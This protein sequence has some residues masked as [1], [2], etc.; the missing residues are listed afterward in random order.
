MKT[1][2]TS[3][4]S[5][6]PGYWLA[7]EFYDWDQPKIDIQA[8]WPYIR[9]PYK[10]AWL[11]SDS[12]SSKKR[13]HNTSRGRRENATSAAD[14][15]RGSSAIPQQ[16]RFVRSGFF[17]VFCGLYGTGQSIEIR[18]LS[19]CLIP[20]IYRVLEHLKTPTNGT[21]STKCLPSSR[22]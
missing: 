9:G 10:W 6:Y 7:Y 4:L 20:S 11:Y 15:A 17:A 1:D 14:L 18:P 12:D 8:G 2:H 22:H 16:G 3:G 19:K 21:L 13:N 5:L